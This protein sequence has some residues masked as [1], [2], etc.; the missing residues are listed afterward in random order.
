MNSFRDYLMGDHYPDP[1]I[2]RKV[3]LTFYLLF[4]GGLATLFLPFVYVA[5]GFKTGLVFSTLGTF[6]AVLMLYWIKQGVSYKVL[7][8]FCAFSVILDLGALV[9]FTGGIFS[10]AL[11]WLLFAPITGYLL[12]NNFSGKVWSFITL[13]FVTGMAV[14]GYYGI[15]FPAL[16]P[17]VYFP[18]V[19]AMNFVLGV[20]I[21]LLIIFSYESQ[22]KKA[23]KKVRALNKELVEQSNET[24]K[25]NKSLESKVIERTSELQRIN[26]ELDH[27][28]YSVSHNLRAPLTSIQGLVDLI[29]KDPK[30][31]EKYLQL[32]RESTRKLDETIHTINSYLKSNRSDV[33]SEGIFVASELKGIISGLAYSEGARELSIKVDISEDLEIQTDRDRFRM[34]FSNIISN[35]IKYADHEK[36]SSFIELSSKKNGQGITIAVADNGIGISDSKIDR[37]FDMFYRGTE[38]SKGDGMGLYIVKEAL[39]KLGGTISLSSEE[40]VGSTFEV[41]FPQ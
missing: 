32:I 41:T 14:L 16:I 40:Q 36:A 11:I 39:S 31:S 17:M 10:P 27:F 9:V 6:L 20:T 38:L 26:E 2:R 37:V 29:V 25:L 34:V 23:V 4:L 7:G 12:T 22:Q 15:E 18:L 5:I 21:L 8:N 1:E 13:F 24:I 3:S 19:K 30:N 28:S 35:A 33:Q